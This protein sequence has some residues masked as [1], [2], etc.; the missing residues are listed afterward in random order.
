MPHQR[1]DRGK[2]RVVIF[3]AFSLK[4]CNAKKTEVSLSVIKY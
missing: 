3:N 1:K 2:Q 4:G